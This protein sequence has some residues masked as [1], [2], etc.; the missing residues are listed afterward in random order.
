M[1]GHN[2]TDIYGNLYVFENSYGTFCSTALWNK[3]IFLFWY[4]VYKG[5][6]VVFIK[7]NRWKIRSDKFYK[8]L[9]ITKTKFWSRKKIKL[10]NDRNNQ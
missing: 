4:T 6:I 8:I 2:S 5:I 1:G 7:K 10:A 3:R 9:R